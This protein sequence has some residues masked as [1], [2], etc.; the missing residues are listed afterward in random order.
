MTLY[1]V[2]Q[3]SPFVLQ[4]MFANVVPYAT[5]ELL[6][7]AGFQ[8]RMSA[9]KS[10][11]T[12]ATL[13]YDM[14][15]ERNQLSLLQGSIMLSS[16]S[17]SYSM[18]KDYRYWLSNATRIATQ[19]GLHRDYIC[20]SLGEHSKRLFRR[21]WWVL[22]NRDMLLVI[23]GID[24]LRRFNDWHCDTAPLKEADLEEHSEIPSAF[25][26]V[27]HPGTRLQRLFLVEYSNLSVISMKLCSSRPLTI[28]LTFFP[29]QVGTSSEISKAQR[30]LR[31][32][33]Q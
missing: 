27:L 30:H 6:T 15:C 4:A 33:A 24:N 9:Q 19:M 3:Q 18:D 14:K 17:F 26:D 13:L 16:L 25:Q 10:F 5:E 8:D 11:Y 29:L 1:K 20:E 7:E 2:E 23:S 22:Y 32:P 21:I 28:Q 31:P 12:K